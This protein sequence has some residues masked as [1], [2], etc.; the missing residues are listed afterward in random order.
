MIGTIKNWSAYVDD[1]FGRLDTGEVEFRFRNGLIYKIRPRT[2][3][4]SVINEIWFHH[5]YPLSKLSSIQQGKPWTTIDLGANIGIYSVYA[6]FHGATVYAFEPHPGNFAQ[7]E[8]N[9]AINRMN[10][11]IH[12]RQV[13]MSDKAGELE[14]YLVEGDNEGG[15]SVVFK[16]GKSIKVPAVQFADA[17]HEAN[18]DACDLLKVDV[19]GAEFNIFYSVPGDLWGRVNHIIVEVHE[20]ISWVGTNER[21]TGAALV[22][23]LDS[24][25]FDARLVLNHG[26][27]LFASRKIAS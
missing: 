10:D 18:I 3:D 17:F 1:Y 22:E 2:S 16:K 20:S 25:G 15:H 8:K 6:A 23:M 12:P 7:L 26:L 9:I 19:E 13:A 11:R 5:C 4:R 21:N 24:K 14:L 27:Y